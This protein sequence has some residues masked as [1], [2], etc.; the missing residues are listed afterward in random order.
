MD[1]GVL[2]A[3]LLSRSGAPAE[4]IL[5][6]IEGAFELI[7]S[8][9]LLDELRTVLLRP[10]FAK[11]VAP[12]DVDAY[13]LLI[14]NGASLLPDPQSQVGLTPD[15]GDDYLVEL[16][17]AAAAHFLISGDPHLTGLRRPNPPVLTPRAFLA[18][19]MKR[20]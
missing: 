6:W 8:P 16:A 11:Y 7:V 9:K 10:K 5:A 13:L 2:I 12:D 3:A 15:P 17:R 18:T 19:L 20:P 4:I 1:P 14:E